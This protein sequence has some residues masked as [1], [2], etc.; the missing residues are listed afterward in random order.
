D[1]DPTTGPQ[2]EIHFPVAEE[3]S[4]SREGGGGGIEPHEARIADVTG[5]GRNDLI[6]LIH[7]RMLVYPQD[8]GT[9]PA[10]QAA[11]PADT[12]AREGRATADPR[13]TPDG[14]LRTNGR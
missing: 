1:Y 11:A 4:V 2:H 3:K 12:R 10:K 9:Q 14:A 6:L 7:D 5:D 13:L 8:S